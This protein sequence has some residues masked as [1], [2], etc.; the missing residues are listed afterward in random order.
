MQSTI[1]RYT[2][3]ESSFL[4]LIKQLQGY[5]HQPKYQELQGLQSHWQNTEL[6]YSL[7]IFVD[8]L[9]DE[10]THH[11]ALLV[12]SI[13]MLLSEAI[14]RSEL[15]SIEEMLCTF[16]QLIPKLYSPLLC[17]A[18]MHTLVHLVQIVRLWGPLYMLCLH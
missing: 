2:A 8:Y 9:P 12:A 18:N 16:Q 14:P 17:T 1:L 13:F 11:I 5:D 7:P 10:Y 15:D 6:F 3:S 4:K